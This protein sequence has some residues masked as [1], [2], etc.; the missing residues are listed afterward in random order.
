M[1][2]KQLRP[3]RYGLGLLAVTAVGMFLTLAQESRAEGNSGDV[4]VMTNQASGNS[5]MV[6]HR[7]AAGSL[8]FTGTFATGGNGSGTGAD[9]LGSQGSLV[10]TEDERFLITVNAG[11]NTVSIFAVDRDGLKLLNDAP[12]G[13]SMPVSV[14]VQHGI[15]YVLNAGG[16]PNISGLRIDPWRNQ[17]VPLAGSTQN[18]PGGA[19]AAPAQVSFSPDGDVL[20]VTEKGTNLLDT[21]R[22]D[23]GIAGAGVS[24][25]ASGM[26]PFGFAF[27]HDDVAIVSNAGAGAGTSTVASYRV[28][29]DG[30]VDVIT[31]ALG[32]TQT[33][34]CWLVVS[35]NGKFAY[36][37][38][39]ASGTIS[40]YA[41]SRDGS[42][43]LV[44]IT[45][46]SLGAGGA[47]IDMALSRN[48]R[49]LY[50]RDAGHGNVSGFRIEADGSLTS[51]GVVSGVPSGAQGVAAR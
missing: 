22:L 30:G 35:R 11:S 12:S 40:S 48:N 10:L 9:P 24:F 7:D 26:T 5:I 29:E 15:V 49:F 50:V 8:V 47:P 14:A 31:P 37:A 21:F 33:A 25:P 3:G 2:A 51:V 17:L 28:E 16:T 39:S 4:Y 41:V 44:N 34:A 36:T 43:G 42:L 46:A 38:N 20:V 45:A 23:D 18:L 27:G 6:F 1:Y 13:G 19:K 32:D